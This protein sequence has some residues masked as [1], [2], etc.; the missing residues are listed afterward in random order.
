VAVVR[1]LDS[2]AAAAAQHGRDRELVENSADRQPFDL[3]L[4]SI[5]I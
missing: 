1:E 2:A 4:R 5:N 3:C